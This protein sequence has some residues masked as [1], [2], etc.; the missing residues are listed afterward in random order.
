MQ[1]S[2]CR[3]EKTQLFCASLAVQKTSGFGMGQN[4]AKPAA[5]RRKVMSQNVAA[6]GGDMEEHEAKSPWVVCE[7]CQL[8]VGTLSAGADGRK[9]EAGND[10]TCKH[11]PYQAC[12]GFLE[13]FRKARATQ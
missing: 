12:P 1:F 8:N 7:E 10:L 13:A 5:N 4:R 6:G 2:K 9:R 11:P 3:I